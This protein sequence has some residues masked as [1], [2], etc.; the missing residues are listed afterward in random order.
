M[1]PRMLG[2]RAENQVEP[3]CGGGSDHVDLA[4]VWVRLLLNLNQ[5]CA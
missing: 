4:N 3:E 2:K 5:P 1:L